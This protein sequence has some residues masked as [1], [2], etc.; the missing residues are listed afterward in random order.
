LCRRVVRV[1]RVTVRV[2]DSRAGRTQFLL[3][4]RERRAQKCHQSC[5]APVAHYQCLL[6][7]QIALQVAQLQRWFGHLARSHPRS[8]LQILT[9]PRCILV[10]LKD[11]LWRFQRPFASGYAHQ[12]W[13]GYCVQRKSTVISTPAAASSHRRSSLNRSCDPLT[14]CTMPERIARLPARR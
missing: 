11:T 2:E 7:C 4:R 12:V 9:D 10:P 14:T 8:A 3:C 13:C 1:C 5:W 6:L